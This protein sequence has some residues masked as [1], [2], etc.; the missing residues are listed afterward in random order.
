VISQPAVSLRN[1]WKVYEVGDQRV[2]AVRGVSLEVAPGELVALVGPSGCGKSTLLNLIGALDRPTRGEVLAAGVPLHTLDDDGLTRYRRRTAGIVF[3]FFNLLPSLTVAE[4]VA[5]PMQIDGRP[6]ADVR[7]RVAALLDRVDLAHR[8]AHRPAQL[9][10]GEQQ[11]VAVARALANEPAILLGDEPTGN[12]DTRASRDL[13]RLF[14]SLARE[15]KRTVLLATH[16]PEVAAAADRVVRMRDGEVVGDERREAG[17]AA[18][19]YPA[20]GR[21]AAA[22]P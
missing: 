1:V 12:L 5:L 13:T 10:G 9:S 2:E 22:S 16:S 20:D 18:P 17:A 4:N 6:A 21:G 14:A 7:A 8:A 15:G 19:A 3:Q 11:R